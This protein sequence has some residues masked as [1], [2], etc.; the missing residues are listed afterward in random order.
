MGRGQVASVL[1]CEGHF[2][3]G[4]SQILEKPSHPVQPSAPNGA[5]AVATSL[6][7]S[8][9]PA[10]PPLSSA[11]SR[12]PPAHWEMPGYPPGQGSLRAGAAPKVPINQ[13]RAL[14]PDHPSH[15]DPDSALHTRVGGRGGCAVT[16]APHLLSQALTAFTLRPAHLCSAPWSR[17]GDRLKHLG[18]QGSCGSAP[19]RFS[20]PRLELSRACHRSQPACIPL[21]PSLPPPAAAPVA[22]AAARS[23]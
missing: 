12:L 6:G 15:P 1:G 21:H 9:K 18:T 4:G 8:G 16:R 23:R 10:T 5:Q 7:G 19:H 2:L 3:P 22:A 20:F 13:W 14:S 11:E 17:A